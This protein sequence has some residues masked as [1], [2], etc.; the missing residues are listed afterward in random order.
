DNLHLAKAGSNEQSK[1]K[2][3]MPPTQGGRFPLRPCKKPWSDGVERLG[4]MFSF[5]PKQTL[6]A[7]EERGLN[8]D[9]ADD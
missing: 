6:A 5:T 3:E 9:Q 1:S 2:Q 4:N 8:H 7:Y